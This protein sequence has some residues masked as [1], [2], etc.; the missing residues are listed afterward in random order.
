MSDVVAATGCFFD[1]IAGLHDCW[2][3]GVLGRALVLVRAERMERGLC[4]ESWAMRVLRL[5]FSYGLRGFARRAARGILSETDAATGYLATDDADVLLR[6]RMCRG[7]HGGGAGDDA[8]DS[9]EGAGHGLLGCYTGRQPPAVPAGTAVPAVPGAKTKC[10]RQSVG[11][12][13]GD[14][15][16]ARSTHLIPLLN[17]TRILFSFRQ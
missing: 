14:K 7:R 5:F 4:A 12:K 13:C 17:A 6:R 10:M 1:R 9:P 11:T 3:K 8:D 15:V 16:K 2:R